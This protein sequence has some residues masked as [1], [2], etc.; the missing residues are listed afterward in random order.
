[1][2]GSFYSTYRPL[3]IKCIDITYGQK[4]LFVYSQGIV[5]Q[6]HLADQNK[7]IIIFEKYHTYT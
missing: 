2:L 4:Y 7:P 1:M 6:R 5:S 3:L